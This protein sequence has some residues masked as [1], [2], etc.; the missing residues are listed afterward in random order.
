VSNAQTQARMVQ[1]PT[2]RLTG[3]ELTRIGTLS[4]ASLA[5]VIARLY[6][7]RSGVF[8]GLTVSYT[9][10]DRV[11]RVD[12]GDG[13]DGNGYPVAV[14]TS[15]P[16]GGAA[17]T[18]VHDAADIQPRIDIVYAR[19]AELD[20]DFASTATRA[21][22]D[23]PVAYS[24]LPHSK[25]NY[26]TLGIVKGIPGATPAAPTLLLAT[27]LLLAETLIAASTPNIGADKVTDRRFI[28]PTIF[29]LQSTVVG[30]GGNGSDGAFSP[31][32]NITITL[33]KNYTTIDIPAGVVVTCHAPNG[34]NDVGML[35]C[36]GAVNNHGTLTGVGG[37]LPGGS[38]GSGG[39]LP[40]GPAG[41]GGSGTAGPA[42]LAGFSVPATGGAGGTSPSSRGSGGGG[43]GNNGNGYAGS[44]GISGGAAGV[45][46]IGNPQIGS[47][48]PY[49][50]LY[51]GQG[52]GGGGGGMPYS[53]QP[54]NPGGVGGAGGA[55][56][57]LEA[58]GIVTVFAGGFL[59]SPGESGAPAGTG[60]GGLEG[61]PGGN[62]A[63]GSLLV[64][65]RGL[66]NNGTISVAAGT[67]PG[68]AAAPGVYLFQQI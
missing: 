65:S 17:A 64:R 19:S 5:E 30:D 48:L 49:P 36:Q 59:G 57:V 56:M 45:G 46:G 8:T 66:V 60:A 21:T 20:G 10:A 62:G 68:A 22:A 9:G 38:A 53:G 7:N 50:T 12:T 2:S 27:D 31:V 32:S 42:T 13:V 29:A 54:G 24:T 35:Y 67:G 14:P 51:P 41:D 4:R 43:G 1:P 34:G 25:L 33:P 15:V 44:V 23:S 55:A 63:G 26:F 40:T 61:A 39:G 52:G 47:R 18:I 11:A 37:G 3:D 58:A 16:P 28:L 6:A